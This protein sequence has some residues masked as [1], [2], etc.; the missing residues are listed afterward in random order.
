MKKITLLF[1]LLGAFTASAQVD[2]LIAL[3][4]N[5]STSQNGRAPQGFDRYNRSIWLIS[6]ADMAA[7][8][9]VAGDGILSIGFNYTSDGL[10]G[11]VQDIPTT[12]SFKVYLQNTADAT[13]TKSTTWATAIASMTLASDATATIPAAVGTV[14]FPFSNGT[15]FSYTGG[16]IYVATDYQN[17][18]GAVASIAN[19]VL[20]TNTLAG[21]L[22]GARSSTAIPTTTA[23]SNFRPET[24]L[25][26]SVSCAKP[27]NIAI[28]SFTSTTAN[29]TFSSSD[30][31]NLEYGVYDFVPGSAAGTTVI[32]VPSPYTFTGLTPSTAYE[33]YAKTNC[34]AF[35]GLSSVAAPVSFHTTYFPA[36]PSYNT[37]FEIDNFPNIGWLEDI[38]PNGSEW[39]TNFGGTGSPL[40]QNGLYSAVSISNATAASNGRMYSRGVNLQAGSPATVSFYI[41]NYQA[42]ASTNNGSFVVTAGTA[43][44]AAAQTIALGSD[45]ALSSAAFVLKTYTFTPTTTGVY[46]FGVLNNSPVNA[47]GVHGLILDNFTVSQTLS[48][49]QFLDSKFSTYPNPANSVVNVSNTTEALLS[50]IEM[51]DL[52]GKVVKNINLS[53]VTEAQVTVSDLSTGV[54]TMKI[55]SDKGIVTKKII[56]E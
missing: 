9:F 23:A 29:L 44:T 50:N 39:F 25:G 33:V 46:H 48:T 18:A 2:N 52:N 36:D 24:R 32:S 8:G 34:G 10:T 41:R 1:L 12:G 5:N 26:K 14:D 38:E 21:G 27:V 31:A 4:N 11:D 30:P 53:E 6:A 35:L 56:K 3:P 15:A 20:C 40:V 42:S 16:A 19:T 54:Y 47:T 17:V 7:A 13:N 51:V 37:S 45:T 43:Q 49:N 22:K 28:P 55:T